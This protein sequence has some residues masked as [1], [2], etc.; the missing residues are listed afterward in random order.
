MKKILL[1]DDD[2]EILE[3][4]KERLLA[5]DREVVT[6][7]NG[8]DGHRLAL[9]EKPDLIIVDIKMPGL[10]GYSLVKNLKHEEDAKNIPVIV[11]TAFPNMREL[12]AVEGVRNY[13]VKPF[14]AEELLQKVEDCL[15]GHGA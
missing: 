11:L 6:A 2:P 1:I 3:L 14:K 9:A 12:F 5:N 13:L 15:S 4:T 8:D 7:S 10:D